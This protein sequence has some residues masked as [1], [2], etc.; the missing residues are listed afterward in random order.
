M[1]IG[2]EMS[3]V[4]SAE[5]QLWS[6]AADSA[7]S[8]ALAVA[9]VASSSSVVSGRASASASRSRED[10]L[11]S[12]EGAGAER[13]VSR[14]RSGFLRFFVLGLSPL[15]VRGLTIMWIFR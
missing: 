14:S 4:V 7:A 2:P 3:E 15:N 11:G 12:L 10:G 5:T 8:S 6:S 9:A 13:S 1:R